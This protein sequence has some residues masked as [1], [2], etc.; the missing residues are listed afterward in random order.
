MDE[1]SMVAARPKAMKVGGNTAHHNKCRLIEAQYWD[2]QSQRKINGSWFADESKITFRKHLNRQIDIKW[3]LRGEAGEANWYEK[4]RH[5]GQIN[6]FLVQSINGIEIY[7][8]YKENMGL[9]RYK[10]LMLQIKER[11]QESNAPFSCYMYDNA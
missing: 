8:I 1:L 5:P 3:V 11:I 9:D 7:D 4:P 10:E 2:K 6:L